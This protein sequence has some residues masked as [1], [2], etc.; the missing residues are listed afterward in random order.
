MCQFQSF[1]NSQT[2]VK[3]DNGGGRG[4]LYLFLVGVSISRRTLQ[5]VL[6]DTAPPVGTQAPSD[7]KAQL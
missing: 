4:E 7:R 5:K 3:S 6:M 2:K 1:L